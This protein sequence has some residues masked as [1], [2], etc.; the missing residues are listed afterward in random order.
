MRNYKFTGPLRPHYPL[1]AKREVPAHIKRPDYADDRESLALP[2][3]AE[4]SDTL[5]TIY[6]DTPALGRSPIEMARER[7]VKTLNAEE[8]EGMRKVCR[9]SLEG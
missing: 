3:K 6:A 7:A 8:I 9:V 5:M 1:S 2:K 4:R